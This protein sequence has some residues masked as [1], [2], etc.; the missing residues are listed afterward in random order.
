MHNRFALCASS[1]FLGTM[2]FAASPVV[3]DTEYKAK[4]ALI[5]AFTAH[6]E[7]AQL[8]NSASYNARRVAEEALARV[9]S[10]ISP[11][12]LVR[13][14]DGMTQPCQI[15]GTFTARMTRS[16]PR[17][18]E[19][20]WNACQY[21][22]DL[23][24]YFSER[25]GA[26]EIVLLSD[27]FTPKHV[28][29]IRLGSGT[30]D[31]SDYRVILDAEQTSYE[32]RSANLRIVG[33][34]PMVRAFPRFGLFTGGFAFDLTGFARDHVVIEFPDP[35][36]PAYVSDSLV[37]WEHMLA[38]GSNVYDAPKTHLVETME[39]HWGTVTVSI[40][41]SGWG[42]QSRAF[43]PDSLRV[44]TESDFVNWT[45]YRAV[46][47]AFDY[48]RDIDG[49]PSCHNG[50]YTFRTHIPY[51]GSLSSGAYDSGDLLINGSTRARFY[52]PANVPPDLPVPQNGMLVHLEV[53]GLGSFDYDIPGTYALNPGT[54]C[55]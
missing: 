2:A 6:G 36:I 10:A 37:T 5:T 20:Q 47:G 45:M 38:S 27:S 8:H 16:Y 21:L 28:A 25:N 19:V 24:G 12:A 33:L 42:R 39:M 35:T 49:Y 18:L 46:N 30:Q 41:Q 22:H 31:F 43:S 48:Q 34:I 55:F 23:D 15:S 54:G 13:S 40:E 17:V 51:G 3:I 7:P 32:T 14:H 29:S 44:R 11:Q 4:A 53:A 9:A 26:A 50:R 1:F 52:S